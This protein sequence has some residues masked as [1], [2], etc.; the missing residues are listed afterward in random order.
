VGVQQVL[1]LPQVCNPEEVAL[2][3]KTGHENAG[4]PLEGSQF[5]SQYLLSD[6][7]WTVPDYL[8]PSGHS[9]ALDGPI[10]ESLYDLT[11]DSLTYTRAKKEGTNWLDQIFRP[12]L[13]QN[14]FLSATHGSPKG[15]YAIT[16]GYF[17]Q[18]GVVN[19][20]K[21]QKLTFRVNTHFNVGSRFR[22]GETFSFSYHNLVN[23]VGMQGGHTAGNIIYNTIAGSREVT[24]VFDVGGYYTSGKIEELGGSNPVAHLERGKDNYNK[25]FR[26][27]GSFFIELDI[28]KDL[29]LKSSISPNLKVTFEHKE[30]E[31]KNPEDPDFYNQRNHLSQYVNN[32]FNWTWYNTLTYHKTFNDIHNLNALVG[33]ETIEDKITTQAGGTSD[34]YSDD[35]SYRHLSAGESDP[36]VEGISSEWSLMS[37][38]A[39][40]DYNYKAKYI[41]SAT[42]RRDGSSRFGGDNKYAVFP[43][44]SAAWRISGENFMW[45][46]SFI[47]DLKL[48]AGWGQTGNQNIGNY[49]ISNTYSTGFMNNYDIRGSQTEAESGFAIAY[50][51]NPDAKWES[52]TTLNIGMDL[53][54]FRNSLTFTFDWYNRY[55]TDML[56]SVPPTA[57]KGMASIGNAYQN[58]GEMRNTGI[59]FSMFYRS[60]PDR[61]F[62]WNAG[63]NFTQYKNEVVKLYNPDQ[64]YW[65]GNFGWTDYG[66]SITMEGYPVSSFYGLNIMGVFNTKSEVLGAP[67]QEFNYLID[68]EGDTTWFDVG[69]WRF[70]DK[71]GNDTIQIIAPKE[72]DR[73]VLGSPHPDFTFGVPINLQFKGFY[74]NMFWYG[75][76]GNEIYNG[77]KRVMDVLK[78]EWVSNINTQYSKRI[79]QSWGMPDVNNSQSTLPQI[80]DAA[81]DMEFSP[82]LSYYVEDGSFL[83]LQQLILGYNFKTTSWKIVEQFRI[84][85]QINNLLTIT[86][87]EGFDPMITR[88]VV[89]DQ[90]EFKN[91]FTLGSDL[92]QYPGA[93]IYMAGLS[94]T[95]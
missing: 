8:I 87:Y 29:T 57:L 89:R 3:Y 24:P 52:T 47:D 88:S 58:V 51:G 53:A 50:F 32:R 82:A 22:I 40:V 26:L 83:R 54:M 95:F 14:Y 21:Y 60:R 1:N 66:S 75:S 78:G 67:R 36:W 46:L 25:Y 41:V 62:T 37:I 16:L 55:T 94:I 19:Y 2:I 81:P 44:F 10:D 64:F 84:Y 45:G 28:L 30:F 43:A 80:N 65:G 23:D 77:N 9:I 39:K 76:F 5:S 13:I 20:N 7:T 63:I 59:D 93:R 79:L 4:I 69:R 90:Y 70:E 85:F 11:V 56:I 35:L 74:I 34:F 72:D 18:E 12:A 73:Y 48:R 49:R 68:P 38:F 27:L 15:H 71:D 6:G 86:N 91:D 31:P 17:D 42:V 33:M 61:D 92:A